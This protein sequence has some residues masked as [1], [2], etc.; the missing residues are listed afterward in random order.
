M[1]DP[2][3]EYPRRVVVDDTDPRI[4]YDTGEWSSGKFEDYGV[5][6]SPYNNTMRR[7]NSEKASFT[8]SFEGDFVQVRGAK[9]NHNIR[10]PFSSPLFDLLSLFPNYTCQID[11]E[12]I[13]YVEYSN[14]TYFT[15]NL[16]LC[17]RAHLS[18]RNHTLT[19]N[20]T[21]NKP[22]N[23]VF[24]LDSIEYHPMENTNLTTEVLKVDS[25][26]P[27]SCFY[28]NADSD[29]EVSD[30]NLT[31][32]NMTRKSSA[33]MSFKFNGTS[34]SLYGI[35]TRMAANHTS[36]DRTTGYYHID[37]GQYVPFDIPQSKSLPLNPGAYSAAW[38]NQH[39]FTTKPVSGDRE[40]ELVISYSGNSSGTHL[41]QWLA[42]D[43]FHVKNE[44]VQLNKA[45]DTPVPSQQADSEIGP[46]NKDHIGA[47]VGGVVSGLLAVAAFSWLIWFII[48]RRGGGS[49]RAGDLED[50]E[51]LV[52]PFD[53]WGDEPLL[54]AQT[55]PR[56]SAGFVANLVHSMRETR[57][58]RDSGYR[59]IAEVPAS[60]V[61]AVPPPYTAL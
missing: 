18:K 55:A 57:Q 7:T 39:F 21:V 10:A 11:G 58:E 9:D 61:S 19:M 25:S 15:T 44:E 22:D 34:V 45:T 12:P 6:G 16:V 37:N 42:I 43:Y 14:F 26:D 59:E 28:H 17:Q 3:Y 1:V 27:R 13:G 50:Q 32:V 46:D 5:R 54:R 41:P 29:W 38:E 31:S 52:S 20:I 56:K 51:L 36:Y 48:K 2:E 53:A 8:F 40:H 60:S 24:W 47:I 23:Q 33:T 4:A 35:N 49:C 30:G